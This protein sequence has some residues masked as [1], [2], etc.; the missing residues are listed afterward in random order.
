M[1]IQL[2]WMYPQSGRLLSISFTL[3]ENNLFYFLNWYLSSLQQIVLSFI[4]YKMESSQTYPVGLTPMTR[5][6]L[7]NS[8]LLSGMLRLSKCT[9]GG[10]LYGNVV[11]PLFLWNVLI[12]SGWAVRARVTRCQTSRRMTWSEAAPSLQPL[13]WPSSP[14]PSSPSSPSCSS[15]PS[16]SPGTIR[17]ERLIGKF[18]KIFFF[19]LIGCSY[20]IRCKF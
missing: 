13:W 9:T 12:T 19:K 14:S 5:S 6:E 7:L 4:L 18:F 2:E 8:S 17:D 3:L 1:L 20:C 16:R 11:W 10:H 15:S